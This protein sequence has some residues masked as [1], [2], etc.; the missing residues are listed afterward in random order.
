MGAGHDH[1]ASAVDVEGELSAPLR[2]L[3]LTLVVLGALALSGGLWLVA[4]SRAI[5]APQARVEAA[6]ESLAHVPPG[7]LAARAAAGASD[8]AGWWW[9]GEFA[10]RAGDAAAARAH[11]ERSAVLA[12][13]RE[14]P[15]RALEA[16]ERGGGA[17]AWIDER[18]ADVLE[19]LQAADIPAARR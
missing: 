2:G 10:R 4:R 8:A 6:L 3:G 18:A 12:P 7:E 13:E 5:S 14:E 17:P 19:G 15:R 1:G 16:L 11:F 9:A